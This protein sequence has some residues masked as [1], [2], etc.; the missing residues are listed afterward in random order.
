M[1]T[2]R[3]CSLTCHVPDQ[4]GPNESPPHTHTDSPQTEI[5]HSHRH[6]MSLTQTPHSE[7]CLTQTDTE[8]SS[9]PHRHLTT[10]RNG[11]GKRTMM[12]KIIDDVDC[13]IAWSLL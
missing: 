1:M 4:S 9:L 8:K 3:G 13:A 6:H 2:L 7:K 11:K 12:I 10:L 5:L